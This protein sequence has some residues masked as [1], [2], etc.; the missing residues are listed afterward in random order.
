MC[1]GSAQLLLP[2][3]TTKAA[4]SLTN[5]VVPYVPAAVPRP[6]AKAVVLALG[7]LF[8]FSLVQKARFHS[9]SSVA[10]HSLTCT[11]CPLRTDIL[12][13]VSSNLSPDL[14]L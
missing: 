1:P 8:V 2:A 14:P 13:T 10:V 7:A 6:I 12:T 9:H 11:S 4:D 3:G 5:F